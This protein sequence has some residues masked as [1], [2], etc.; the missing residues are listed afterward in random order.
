VQDT[1]NTTR[2]S[3]QDYAQELLNDRR[4]GAAELGRRALQMIGEY[5]CDTRAATGAELIERVTAMGDRLA[6]LRANMAPI[7]NL[8]E[9]WKAL[10]KNAPRDDVEAARAYALGMA[11]DLRQKSLRAAGD[12]ARH[13]RRAI[14]ANRMVMTHGI[15]STAIEVLRAMREDG[16]TA[17]VTEARP[18]C[19]GRRM[20]EQL[21]Q[22]GIPTTLITDAQMGL[23]AAKVDCV[24]VGA[25]SVMSDGTSINKAGTYLMALAARE[26]A[27][28][29]YVACET[30]KLDSRAL[31]EI[32]L[33]E[34]DPGELGVNA[35]GLTVRNIYFEPTPPELITAWI[36]EVGEIPSAERLAAIRRG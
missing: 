3:I 6:G 33:E 25:D 29:F 16:V 5:A 11:S 7:R 9:S 31:D 23:Y 1:G 24:L 27:R 17:V 35:P 13:A 18:L 22:E 15:S 19:E 21:A 28:P 2:P 12:I 8:I 34:N 20:A 4:C 36:T 14:G 30:F 26:A 10:L 32:E